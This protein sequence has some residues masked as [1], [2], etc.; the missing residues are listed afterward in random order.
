[1]IRIQLPRKSTEVFLTGALALASLYLAAFGEAPSRIDRILLFAS[2]LALCYF[3]R[4]VL[5]DEVILYGWSVVS[6]IWG[7][8]AIFTMY[9]IAKEFLR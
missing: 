2:T 9:M 5:R 3:L 6:V 8:P 4:K 1:M 7:I